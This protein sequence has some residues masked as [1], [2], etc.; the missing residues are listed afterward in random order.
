MPDTEAVC[1]KEKCSMEKNIKIESKKSK[2]AFM[3]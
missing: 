2:A 3:V 1:R